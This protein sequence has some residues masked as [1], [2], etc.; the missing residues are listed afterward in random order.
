MQGRIDEVEQ[1]ALKGGAKIVAK[2]EQQLKQ[3]ENEL[4]G[5]QR[6]H[7]DASKNLGKVDRR[8]REVQFQV[9]VW[10]FWKDL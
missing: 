4:E 10:G 5:E 9:S 3:I 7:A 8:A 1:A 2:L 6:R